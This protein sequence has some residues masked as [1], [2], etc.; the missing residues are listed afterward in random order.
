MPDVVLRDGS[1][2]HVRRV[3]EDDRPALAALR[4]ELSG[5]GQTFR[6]FDGPADPEG[7][8]RQFFAFDQAEGTVLVG[9]AG[10][11]LQAVAGFRRETRAAARAEVGLAVAPALQGRGI[12]T[13]L[14]EM[15][16][17][18]AR[19]IDVGWFDAWVSRRDHQIVDLF[20]SSGFDV[21]QQEQAGVL[22]LALRLSETARF[23]ERRAAR[24][25]EAAA[26]SMRSFFEP[27]SV[28]VV[29]ASRSPGKIGSEVLHNLK[30]AGFSGPIYPIHPA[31]GTLDGLSAYPRV[32]DA[33]G[34]VD[35]AVVVV[36]APVVAGVIDDCISK[37]VRAIVVVTA[38]FAETGSAGR[39]L[40]ASL[41]DKVRAAGVRM[42]GP[43]CMGLVNT[44]P[45]V[46]LNATFSPVYPPAGHV[47]MST[48][49]GALGLAILDYAR[50]LGIGIST[51]VSV[52]N[53]AD[54]SSNDL[55]Q[56]WADDERTR[57]ILL[58]VESFGNPRKFGQ[59]ARRVGRRKPIVAVKSGRSAAGARAATSHTGALASSDAIVSALFRQAGV[60]RTNTLEELFDVAVVLA[61]QPVPRGRRVAIVTNAGGPGILAA[62][63]CEAQGLELP[64]LEDATVAALRSFLPAAAAIGNPVDMI[65]SAS[66]EHYERTLG[67]VLADDRV[68]SALVIFIPPLVTKADDVA[69]AVKRASTCRPDKPVLG[70]F[71]SAQLVPGLLAPI[72]CFT[73]PEAAAAALSRVTD[74]GEWLATPVSEAPPTGPE[75]HT[76]WQALVRAALERGG[77]WLTPAEAQALV[78][79]AGIAAAASRVA[80]TEAEAVEAADAIGY[81]VVVK[82]IGPTIVHKT[83]LDGVRVDVG[84][85]KAV[86]AVWR[87]FT[88]RLRSSMTGVLVQEMVA[89]GVEMLVGATEDPVFGPVVACATGGVFSELLRDAAF[90][91][92]PLT[93][94]DA[95]A[96]VDGLRGAALL[97]GHRGAPPADRA[98]LEET[99]LKVSALIGA[100]PEI[101]EM[102]INPLAVLPHG[103]KAVDVRIRVERPKPPARTRRV[104]Y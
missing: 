81:P 31:G 72:P 2:L 68:D 61:H 51:F 49:S 62:D 92:H 97:A 39:A 16:A 7:W 9:E 58:Y 48:Q 27:Q 50:R 32:T 88:G 3:R 74:Y 44:D 15:L 26:A 73:F 98:A 86:R 87:D 45:A 55:I 84:D 42:V 82:V 96:M 78:A 60:I 93:G 71:M 104:V 17:D 12:G 83:E 52:G 23:L 100:C 20:M 28:A 54:V 64:R 43:N 30:A 89:G 29:G 76:A 5:R 94:R 65:A 35:L 79:A 67:A 47:A 10:G 19:A 59:I 63:A 14:L 24:A 38:G 57:V 69:A 46:R 36:P 75:D 53:K 80:A 18:A 41:V 1:T 56:Y 103:V 102:D 91:L 90:R 77:G 95:T 85:A 6:L 8:L 4:D 25:Q 22:H 11:R 70:I 13:R 37:G 40:E 101:Q 34:P 99:L 21:E 33:P 66:A